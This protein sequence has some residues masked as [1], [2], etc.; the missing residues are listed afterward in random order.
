MAIE[1]KVSI[2]EYRKIMKDEIS[3][4]DLITKRL[5][6]L[7]TFCRNIIRIE[8]GKYLNKNGKN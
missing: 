2:Q 1:R 5:R 8:L 4:E 6:F 7:E 3:P